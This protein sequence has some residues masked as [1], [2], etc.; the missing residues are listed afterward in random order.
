MVW[1]MRNT[2]ISSDSSIR[3]ET[4]QESGGFVSGSTPNSNTG[5]RHAYE[6]R[7]VNN[8]AV[9]QLIVMSHCLDLTTHPDH[10]CLS[11]FPFAHDPALLDEDLQWQAK[12][13]TCIKKWISSYNKLFHSQI[14]LKQPQSQWFLCP[15]RSAWSFPAFDAGRCIDLLA[16][17]LCTWMYNKET[18]QYVVTKM[19]YWYSNWKTMFMFKFPRLDEPSF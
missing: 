1:N 10:W 15:T 5:D 11:N 13:H 17:D 16:Q 6:T 14:R 7:S 8:G 2:W 18:I 19:A 12:T 3:Y 4:T 9:K